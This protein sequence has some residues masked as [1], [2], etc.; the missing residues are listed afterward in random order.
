MLI[1]PIE[2]RPDWTRPPLVTAGLILLNLMVF[3]FYQ[4]QD[5]A[6]AQ[7][8]YDFYQQ[9]NLLV[10]E[11]ELYLD[12]LE[13]G[14]VEWGEDRLEQLQELDQLQAPELREQALRWWILFDRGFDR[15]LAQKR[16]E[17]AFDDTLAVRLWHTDRVR[18]EQL[19]DRLSSYRGG[20]TPAD[21]KPLSFLTSQFLHGGWGHLIGNMLFLFLF[22]FTLEA[23]LR[24]YVYLGM[25]LLSGMAANGLHLWLNAESMIPV[26]G[27]S[28]AISGL[29]GMYLSLYRL[30]RI[31]FFYTVFFYFGEF[32]APA[33][34]IL[35][36]WLAKELYG[37]FFFDDS[38]AYWAHIGGLLTGACLMFALPRRQQAF[39]RQ[40]QDHDRKGE[41]ETGLQQVQ[42]AMTE[43]DFVRAKRRCRQLCEAYPQDP[44]PWQQLFELH[45]S[46][47]RQKPF[48]QVTFELLKQFVRSGEGFEQWHA[49]VQ[50]VLAD[51]RKLA[52]R[53]P[54][55]NASIC[56]ALARHYWRHRRADESEAYLRRA[57]ELEASPVG[58]AKLLR[59]MIAH[60]QQRQQ[61]DKAAELVERL[62][63]LPRNSV[64]Q[65]G[66]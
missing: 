41:L 59:A 16:R 47:P 50:E 12:Y 23:V 3:L 32:R 66:D 21:A 1:F 38:T 53:T 2:N 55:L 40:L 20:L 52:P 10:L 4:G 17:N 61:P 19:R 31:R 28:G 45:K 14:R 18:F 33:L 65:A 34:A 64:G 36:L 42:L 11:R 39:A 57:I 46:Q 13:S 58:L 62:N 24:P 63:R 27:A 54:A 60:Y 35:P 5:E 7:A 48:H 8:A 37:H 51:Y 29:M 26:I 30:R 56:L 9:H 6:R 43:L 44:R 22:G 49:C 25:Y 15:Y